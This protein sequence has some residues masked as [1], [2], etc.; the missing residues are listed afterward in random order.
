MEVETVGP[1]VCALLPHIK[2]PAELCSADT[3][4]AQCL[5]SSGGNRRFS[6]VVVSNRVSSGIASL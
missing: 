6:V 1:V 3:L 5:D 4:S 2:A